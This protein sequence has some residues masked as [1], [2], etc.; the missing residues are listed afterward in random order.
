MSLPRAIAAHE[1]ALAA[2]E[3]G[4]FAPAE[5]AIRRAADLYAAA[6]GL[7][8]PD[9]AN[10]LVLLG[11]LRGQRDDLVESVSCYRRALTILG[12]PK[13]GVDVE[14]DRLRLRA[15]FLL[16]SALR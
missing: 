5:R 2:R 1:Q 8:H 10:A 15:T 14:L 11:E 3:A 12:R 6:E 4:R 16:G 13:A 9:V 7:R